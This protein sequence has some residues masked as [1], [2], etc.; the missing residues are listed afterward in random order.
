MVLL[1]VFQLK[2]DVQVL[3]AEIVLQLR[4][5]ISVADQS[6]AVFHVSLVQ[7]SAGEDGEGP[8]LNGLHEDDGHDARD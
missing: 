8:R 7:G 6:V 1:A 5:L 4:G 3:V 2:L